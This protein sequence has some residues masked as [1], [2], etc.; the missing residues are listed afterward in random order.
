MRTI[1]ASFRRSVESRFQ[2]DA[3]LIFVSISHPLLIEP[4]RVVSDT[5]DYF[6]DGYLWTGFPFDIQLLTDDD[7]PPRAVIEI[8]NVDRIIGNTIRPLT[9]APRLKIELLHSDDFD[10][11]LDPRMPPGGSPTPTVEYSAPNLFLANVKIDAMTVAGDI[12]GWDFTQ[13]TWPGVRASQNRLPG[14]FR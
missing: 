1:S 3:N 4:V 13:R 9:S 8:Q 10:L 6:W 7:Q 12:V 2:A 11:T 5:K 14:L